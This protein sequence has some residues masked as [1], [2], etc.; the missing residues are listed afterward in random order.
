V[1]L[2][3]TY[4]YNGGGTKYRADLFG[5]SKKLC[6]GKKEFYLTVA[7][8]VPRYYDFLQ[9]FKVAMGTALFIDCSC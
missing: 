1:Y 8:P 3:G 2:F 7:F 5:C 4:K 9:G 6:A